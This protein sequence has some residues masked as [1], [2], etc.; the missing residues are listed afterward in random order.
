[1]HHVVDDLEQLALR[2][3]DTRAVQVVL[4]VCV[5]ALVRD[6]D[7]HVRIQSR[8]VGKSDEWDWVRGMEAVPDDLVRDTPMTSAS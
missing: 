6:C 7:M 1:M 4:V 8:S 3:D 2:P 5:C